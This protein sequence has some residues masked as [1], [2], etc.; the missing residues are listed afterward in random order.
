MP[1]SLTIFA[2]YGSRDAAESTAARLIQ[3]G[4]TASDISVLL[5]DQLPAFTHP[6]DIE[7]KLPSQATPGSHG[8]LS[9]ALG[10]LAGLSMLALPGLGPLVGEGTLKAGLAGLGVDA[11]VGNFA[12]YLINLGVPELEA[13]RYEDRLQQQAVLFTVRCD[14]PERAGQ[15]SELLKDTGAQDLCTVTGTPVTPEAAAASASANAPDSPAKRPTRT[16][17]DRTMHKVS[18]EEFPDS[19]GTESEESRKHL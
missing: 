5:P 13:K 2:L 6:T 16:F 8:I 10:V 4:V 3:S 19:T 9:G 11:A 7:P 1:T 18:P 14:T 15:L 17:I 12:K